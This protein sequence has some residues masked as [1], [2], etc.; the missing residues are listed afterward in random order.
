MPELQYLHG[1]NSAALETDHKVVELRRRFTVRLIN[2]DS[3]APR[4]TV[5]RQIEAAMNGDGPVAFIGTSLGGYFAAVMGQR[6]RC[7]AVMINP[8]CDPHWGLAH[9]LGH[10]LTNPKL[11]EQPARTLSP[12]TVE[13]YAGHELSPAPDDYAIPPKLIVD[14][15]DELLDSQA[16]LQQYGGLAEP[17]AFEGGSHRFEHMAE[18]LDPIEAYLRHT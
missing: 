3:F 17:L 7:P 14:L 9:Y 13:S 10:S 4:E 1:F 16:T 6:H 2:Y 8:S 15:G 5:I 18:A 11:P 12:E